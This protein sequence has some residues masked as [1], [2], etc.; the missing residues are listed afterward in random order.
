[1]NKVRPLRLVTRLPA[2]I[3]VALSGAGCGSASHHAAPRLAPARA[4]VASQVALPE[5]KPSRAVAG[6]Q[7]VD[8]S[9]FAPGACVAFSPTGAARNLTV[10][11]DAGHG[12]RDP[13][14]VGITMSGR[15]VDEARLTLRVELETMALLRRDGFRV[16]VSRTRD[17][18]MIHLGRGDTSGGILTPDGSHDDVT[19][20]DVCANDARANVLIGIYFNAGGPS[21][22]GSVTGYDAVRPFAAANR[23]LATLVQTDVL[24]AMNAHGWGIPDEGVAVDTGLGSAVNRRAKAYGHLTLLGPAKAGWLTT[25]SRMPGALIEPL[26]ITDPFEASIAAGALGRRVIAGGIARAVIAYFAT[27]PPP[28]RGAT[29]PGRTHPFSPQQAQCCPGSAAANNRR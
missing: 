11:L 1:M 22:A 14:A 7:P 10:F 6:G 26:F 9:V 12:G 16:V 5:A 2:L 27:G 17:T 8:P 20:R 13:G 25:P 3:A 28:A 21:N 18:S 24:A 29:G 19:A 4:A 23:R 15:P